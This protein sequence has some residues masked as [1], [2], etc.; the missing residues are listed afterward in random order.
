LNFWENV[1]MKLSIAPIATAVS[2]ALGS[3]AA[4]AQ[5][6]PPGIGANSPADQTSLFLLAWNSSSG[7]TEIVNLQYEY[8]A[9][10][11][12]TVGIG[13]SNPLQTPSG[14]SWTTV[15]NPTG[16]GTVSQ[17]SFGQIANATAGGFNE[18]SIAVAAGTTQSG[19]SP[20]DIEGV[21][22]T[23]GSAFTSLATANVTT[24]ITNAQEEIANWASQTGCPTGCGQFFDS[25]ASTTI[26]A[27]P[28]PSSS[29]SW[30]TTTLSGTAVG[31][32]AQFYQILANVNKLATEDG[33]PKGGSV[34][35]PYAG[36]FFLDSSGNLSYDVPTATAVPLPPAVWLFGGGL[37]GMIGVARRRRAAV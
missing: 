31:S 21:G 4:H 15:A 22:I 8:Q 23:S 28:A 19:F 3:M 9:I 29:G 32:A 7:A 30:G 10:V 1:F 13:A 33:I 26:A 36:F 14:P 2:L 12:T 20:T 18:Y 11:G 34:V 16:A 27:I 35:T 25:N 17:L 6:A 24:V 37:L 5:L